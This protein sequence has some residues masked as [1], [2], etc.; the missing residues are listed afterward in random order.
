MPR[1]AELHL[2]RRGE[3]L[4]VQFDQGLHCLPLLLFRRAPPPL[5]AHLSR[6]IR[7]ELIVYRSSRRASVGP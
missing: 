3:V 1:Q 2:E 6:R 4:E 5:L 7:G